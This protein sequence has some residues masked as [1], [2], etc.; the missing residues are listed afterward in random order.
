MQSSSSMKR[1]F[2]AGAAAF[3]IF[4]LGSAFV[5]V[6]KAGCADFQP[7]KKAVSW[8][9]PGSFYGGLSFLRVSN[10]DDRWQREDIVGIC[11]L[12]CPCSTL[13][14]PGCRWFKSGSP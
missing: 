14:P 5:Q 8:Q 9:T 6:A 11:L 1:T 2:K 4:A 7:A 13:P 3:G 10:D 12:P